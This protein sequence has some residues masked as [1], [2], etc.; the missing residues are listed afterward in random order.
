MLLRYL[1]NIKLGK[2]LLQASEPKLKG[3]PQMK[4]AFENHFGLPSKMVTV[5][6]TL[7][8]TSGLLYL[9]SFGNKKMTRIASLITFGVLGV[10]A[11]KHYEAGDGK[12]GAQ[13]ALDLL[14]LAG[15]STLDTITL[16]DCKK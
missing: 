5:A 3:D 1:N 11:Y 6:G 10:A 4:D 8:A 15:L 14:K 7:E 13:H 12:A 9:L 16:T 2:E